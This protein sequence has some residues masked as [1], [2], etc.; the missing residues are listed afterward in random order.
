IPTGS[1]TLRSFSTPATVFSGSWSSCHTRSSA[2]TSRLSLTEGAS[3]CGVTMAMSPSRGSTTA[4]RRSLRH[5]C[6]PVKYT[7]DAPGSMS[8]APMPCLAMSRRALSMRNRYSSRDTG[9]T[10]PVMDLNSA[11]AASR[12]EGR[13]AAA[14]A[15]A[16]PKER[17]CRR[18][19][20]SVL[21]VGLFFDDGRA[22]QGIDA[23]LDGGTLVVGE[24]DRPRQLDEFLREALGA[25]LVADLVL[26]DPEFLVDAR[27]IRLGG[28]EVHGRGSR[29]LPGRL[30][31]AELVFDVRDLVG[32]LHARRLDAQDGD[33]VEQLARRDGHLDIF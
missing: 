16:T 4:V 23:L 32:V 7:I 21:L 33:L 27:E 22:Q 14:V 2:G 10:S 17:A 3:K 8:S 30:Q 26:D 1:L 18:V 9:L 20:M 31:Q 13:S 28:T 11:G 5:Q 15:A 6:T 25:L 19:N 29:F 24:V 12:R